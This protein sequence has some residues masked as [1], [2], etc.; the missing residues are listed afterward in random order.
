MPPEGADHRIAGFG[1]YPGHH[2]QVAPQGW[3]AGRGL[4]ALFERGVWEGGEVG[5]IKG[6]LFNDRLNKFNIVNP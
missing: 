6:I 5:R 2:R 3:P 1:G 4:P